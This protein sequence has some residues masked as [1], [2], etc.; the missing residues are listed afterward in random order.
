MPPGASASI[1]FHSRAVQ[2]QVASQVWKASAKPDPSSV[3]LCETRPGVRFGRMAGAIFWQVLPQLYGT[4]EQHDRTGD[5]RCAQQV[6]NDWLILLPRH[7][8]FAFWD[9]RVQKAAN[10]LV[11]RKPLQAWSA[12]DLLSLLSQN[13]APTTAAATVTLM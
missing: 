7:M 4:V 2:V 12:S 13:K 5:R 3:M 1:V 11:R 9:E 8:E 10:V 6:T